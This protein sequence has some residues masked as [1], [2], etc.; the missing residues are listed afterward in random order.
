MSCRHWNYE[1]LWYKW[2]WIETCEIVK[3]SSVCFLICDSSVV[4]MCSIVQGC[5][6]MYFILVDMDSYIKHPFVSLI[7]WSSSCFRNCHHIFSLG[8]M[9]IFH[10]NW[11]QLVTLKKWDDKSVPS[12]QD[13][14]L[15][16]TYEENDSNI[17]IL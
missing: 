14:S 11:W 13:I 17:Y 8:R 1:Y 10:P 7:E 9:T 3:W 16:L 6:L 12:I 15:D 4:S 5:V 2:I